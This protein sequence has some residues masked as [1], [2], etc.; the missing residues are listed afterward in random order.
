MERNRKETGKENVKEQKSR[1]EQKKW[2]NK[3]ENKISSQFQAT[4]L[5]CVCVCVRLRHTLIAKKIDILFI[6]VHVN[7]IHIHA[8]TSS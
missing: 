2:I 1:N 3:K 7:V 6:A 5:W 8:V 4:T